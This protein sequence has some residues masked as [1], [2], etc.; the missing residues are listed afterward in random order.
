MTLRPYVTFEDAVTPIVADP[1][2]GSLP[3][4]RQLAAEI[5]QA[6][7]ARGVELVRPV[8]QWESYGWEFTVRVEQ[9]DVW[10]MLQ[11]SDEWLVLSDVRKK[12]IERIRG[13]GG[14]EQHAMAVGVLA[15]FL[16][17]SRFSKVTWFTKAEFES[18]SAGGSD[19]AP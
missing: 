1:A 12:M 10:F 18:G 2:D 6:L 19:G 4:G 5:A 7:Q 9:R 11:R 16:A 8:S 14:E 3:P 15:S 13:T 17:A